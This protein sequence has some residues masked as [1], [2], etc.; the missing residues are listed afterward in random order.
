MINNKYREAGFSSW[1]VSNILLHIIHKA[2]IW[3]DINFT[4][5]KDNNLEL[6]EQRGG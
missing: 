4:I 6:T 3:I 1:D 5:N 2:N